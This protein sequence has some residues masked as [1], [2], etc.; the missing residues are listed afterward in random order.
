MDYTVREN[1]PGLMIFIDFQKAFDS[2]E[3]DYLLKCLEVFNFG[4]NFLR[5]VETFYKN[6]QGCV[7]NNGCS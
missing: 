4:P 5:W 2:L 7:I 1:V 3:W 6:I